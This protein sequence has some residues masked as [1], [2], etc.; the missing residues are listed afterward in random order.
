MLNQDQALTVLNILGP[1][2]GRRLRADWLR[3]NVSVRLPRAITDEA[4]EELIREMKSRGWISTRVDEFGNPLYG[5][6]EE[7]QL[8]REKNNQ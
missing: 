1:F 8:V 3:N 4:F 2:D 5:I 6:T 7:G